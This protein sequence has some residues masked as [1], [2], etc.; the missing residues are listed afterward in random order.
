MLVTYK[1]CDEY[2][3]GGDGSNNT[4]SDNP[5]SSFI[6]LRRTISLQREEKFDTNNVYDSGVLNA[7]DGDVM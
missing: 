1:S 4:K 5:Y 7:V 6:I 2:V 3:K